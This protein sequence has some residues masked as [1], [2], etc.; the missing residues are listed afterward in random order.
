LSFAFDFLNALPDLAL[1]L[2]LELELKT[3]SFN[4]QLKPINGG[5]HQGHK[6]KPGRPG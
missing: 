6:G 1:A 4:C 5:I 2:E 3:H